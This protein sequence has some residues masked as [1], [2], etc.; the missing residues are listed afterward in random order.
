MVDWRYDLT[1]SLWLCLRPYLGGGFNPDP[2]SKF[3]QPLNPDVF[4]KKIHVDY[5]FRPPLPKTNS[6]YGPGYATDKTFNF[7]VIVSKLNT[8]LK[9]IFLFIV[10][11]QNFRLHKRFYIVFFLFLSLCFLVKIP[12]NIDLISTQYW[13]NEV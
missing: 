4:W 6:R 3:L 10:I 13:M 12:P 1:A 2:P 11:K 8:I 9:H 5:Y 7:Q